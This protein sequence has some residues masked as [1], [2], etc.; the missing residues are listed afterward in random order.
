MILAKLE[1]K[2]QWKCASVVYV[3]EM[4]FSS[5][6]TNAMT[7]LC[8][9]SY[10]NPLFFS[11]TVVLGTTQYKIQA[12]LSSPQTSSAIPP[13]VLAQSTMITPS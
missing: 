3:V 2:N 6:N 10:S 13:T 11:L 8:T 5:T 9:K 4:T 12:S 1:G 7:T